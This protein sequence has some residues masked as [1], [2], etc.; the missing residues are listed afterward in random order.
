MTRTMESQQVK[1]SRGEV[2][3]PNNNIYAAFRYSGPY[4]LVDDIEY[5]HPTE[6][7]L[8][9]FITKL[10]KDELIEFTDE[11][12]F[13]KTYGDSIKSARKNRNEEISQYNTSYNKQKMFEKK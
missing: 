13:S 5:R 8:T 3:V 11:K 9:L 7:E 12:T 6:N 1:F 2:V 4:D 10:E